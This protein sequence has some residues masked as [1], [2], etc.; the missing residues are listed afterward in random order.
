MITELQRGPTV[1]LQVSGRRIFLYDEILQPEHID[2]I[3]TTVSAMR[4]C[5]TESDQ[6]D[7]KEV[8]TFAADVTGQW[9]AEEPL[10]PVI[11][12]LVHALFPRDDLQPYRAYINCI[13]YGDSAYPH[14]DCAPDR[15]DVT[16]L[17]YVNREWPRTWCGETIFFEDNGD[18]RI[19]IAPCPGRLV[20]FEGAIEHRVGVPSRDCY[21][22]RLTL[23]YKFKA[24][25]EWR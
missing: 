14:R 22:E 2:R 3:H 13:V 5:R 17:Y 1:D 7:T 9:V 8:R 18:P 10:F 24:P 4:F 20:I 25:G 15:K 19:A 16:A 11:A 6:A 21:V 12:A 23:A